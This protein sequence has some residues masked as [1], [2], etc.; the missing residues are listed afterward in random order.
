MLALTPLA[1]KDIVHI[2]KPIVELT[3][4]KKTLFNTV[5]DKETQNFTTTISSILV[6]Q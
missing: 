1:Q 5:L 3:D 6:Y 4:R 2:F